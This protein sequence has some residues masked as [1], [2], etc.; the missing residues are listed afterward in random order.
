[1][2]LHL[3]ANKV[4]GQDDL[5][6]LEGQLTRQ[7]PGLTL[8]SALRHEPAL[9]RLERGEALTWN[10]FSLSNRDELTRLIEES[11]PSSAQRLAQHHHL[12]GLEQRHA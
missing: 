10:D 6:W 8:S 12:R 1:M 9:L 11:G 2:K 3:I 5:D 4:H 7:A